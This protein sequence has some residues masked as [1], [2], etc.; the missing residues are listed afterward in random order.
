M[1]EGSSCPSSPLDVPERDSSTTGPI[2]SPQEVASPISSQPQEA[3]GPIYTSLSQDLVDGQ[4]LEGFSDSS[5]TSQLPKYNMG[6][7]STII[8]LMHCK[9]MS[10]LV[11]ITT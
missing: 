4:T 2:A 7:T 10:I 8:M 11:K 3:A 5:Q 9:C 6:G 1:S